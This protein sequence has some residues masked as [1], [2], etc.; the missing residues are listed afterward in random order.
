MLFREYV[1][2]RSAGKGRAVLE[3]VG[4]DSDAIESCFQNNL[5]KN[6][7]A[8][9]AGLIQWKDSQIQGFPPTWGVLIGAMKYAKVAKQHIDGLKVALCTKLGHH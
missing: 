5:L 8:V 7:D 3:G 6:E 4:L 1:S 2:R 9:Q